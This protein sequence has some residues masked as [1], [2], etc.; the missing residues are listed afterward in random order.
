[1]RRVGQNT[2]DLVGYGLGA[3]V[4]KREIRSRDGCLSSISKR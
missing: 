1:L 4:I 2:G 3:R